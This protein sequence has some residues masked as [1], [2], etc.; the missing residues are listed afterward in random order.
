[1][2]DREGHVVVMF[3]FVFS[4]KIRGLPLITYAPRGRGGSSLLYI[5]IAYYMQ[6]GGEGVQIA[7]KNVYV[8][9]GRPLLLT[10]NLSQNVTGSFEGISNTQ[11]VI[12]ADASQN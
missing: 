3:F 1:M 6:K 4:Y 9:N 2:D 5:S 10:T 8:I 11:S 7:C 12:F